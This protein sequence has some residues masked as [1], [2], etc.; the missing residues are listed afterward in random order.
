MCIAA[1]GSAFAASGATSLPRLSACGDGFAAR[2]DYLLLG[3]GDGSQF[4]T[5]I[6]WTDWTRRTAHGTAVWW[7]NLCTPDCAT[8]N[9]EHD[10]VRV[11][12]SRPR[13]CRRP[14][15]VLFT[16][17]TLRSRNER[18]TVVKVPYAGGT[19]CP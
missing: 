7:R 11:T 19:R 5:H 16:R 15:A 4:L 3:C 12:L 10:Q 1:L 13:V 17:M 14:A 8:G 9:F 2:P 18:V 6:R